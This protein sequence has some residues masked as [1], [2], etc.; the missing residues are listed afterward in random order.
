MKPGE[1]QVIEG[2]GETLLV[3]RLLAAKPA[4]LDEAAAAPLIEQ[5]LLQR[6]WREAIDMELRQ[7]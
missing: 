1:V 5:F 6:R 4:P 2:G 7:L 3:V